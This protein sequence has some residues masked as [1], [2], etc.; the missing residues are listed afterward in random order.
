MGTVFHLFP[1]IRLSDILLS[2]AEAMHHAYGMSADPEG[3]GLTA[4]EAIQK[5]VPEQDS[6]Q[7]IN[8]LMG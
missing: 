6:E 3:Y 7:M 1:M 2:Y 4:I 5:Y 8:F